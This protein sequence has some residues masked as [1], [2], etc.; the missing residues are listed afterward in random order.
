M[1][2][3]LLHQVS[4]KDVIILG[5]VTPDAD[6]SSCWAALSNDERARAAAFRKRQSRDVYVATHGT[7]RG[8]LSDALDVPAV[9]L[10]FELNEW[11]KPSLCPPFDALHFNI[12]HSHDHFAVGLSRAAPIGIDIEMMS[13]D[14]HYEISA[15]FMSAREF[16]AFSSLTG[17][18][19]Q[20]LFYD[21]WVKK[22]A[23]V[24]ALGIGLSLDFRQVELLDQLP[25]AIS[26]A[27][28]VGQS[29]HRARFLELPSFP[30]FATAAVSLSE[31]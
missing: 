5:R 25:C 28:A 22:E 12:S 30:E 3:L 13:A 11:G 16:A 6:L 10:R 2:D 8:A 27:A 1:L 20:H 26:A 21:L 17:R 7:L 4:V 9:D 19:K 24:K 15:D 14:A 18:R 29:C 23:F 31:G